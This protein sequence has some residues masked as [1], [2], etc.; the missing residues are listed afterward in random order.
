MVVKARSGLSV[1]PAV[2]PIFGIFLWAA[3]SFLHVDV[4][5]FEPVNQSVINQSHRV[6]NVGNRAKKSA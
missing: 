5:G 2:L 4:N 1:P 3:V 6:C